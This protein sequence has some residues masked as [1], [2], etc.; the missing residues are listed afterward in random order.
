MQCIIKAYVL[1]FVLCIIKPSLMDASMRQ[2]PHLSYRSCEMNFS[3]MQYSEGRLSADCCCC[4]YNDAYLVC[5]YVITHPLIN[6]I[7]DE[8]LSTSVSTKNN[9]KFAIRL[10][11]HL[12]DY[13]GRFW[14]YSF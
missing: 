1:C 12:I 10:S 3:T 14:F 7:L 4:C 9:S 2:N 11:S 8:L 6:R 13:G 5:Q